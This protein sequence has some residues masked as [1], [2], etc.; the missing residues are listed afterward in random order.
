M[1]HTLHAASRSKQLDFLRIRDLDSEMV[2]T[3][4]PAADLLT[5]VVQVDGNLMDACL[6][7][8]F[9]EIPEKRA[10]EDRY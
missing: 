3:A 5:A 4:E 8:V 10:I 9:D 6:P 7:H 1:A 2:P